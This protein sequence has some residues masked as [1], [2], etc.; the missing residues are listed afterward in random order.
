[1]LLLR[2]RRRS[3]DLALN[4]EIPNIDIQ[5]CQFHQHLSMGIH[6]S[7][8][9]LAALGIAVVHEADS[10]R[11]RLIILVGTARSANVPIYHLG[12]RLSDRVGELVTCLWLLLNR[13]SILL[14][15]TM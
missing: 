10:L 6:H 1:M 15:V 2:A 3:A 12:A 13:W 8:G 4:R 11:M 5:L 7:G 9:I 14:L